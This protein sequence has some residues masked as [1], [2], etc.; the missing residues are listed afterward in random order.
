MVINKKESQ[1][2]EFCILQVKF[3]SVIISIASA[4]MILSRAI[5]ELLIILAKYFLFSQ[6]HTAGFQIQF[7]HIYYAFYTRINIY[8]YPLLI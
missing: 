7:F 1:K 4:F 8:H 6:L 2:Y 3:F 5:T